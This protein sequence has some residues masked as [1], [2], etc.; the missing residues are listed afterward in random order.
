MSFASVIMENHQA[1][2][3]ASKHLG[4]LLKLQQ[5][6][7]PERGSGAEGNDAT[8]QGVL[9]QLFTAAEERMETDNDKRVVGLLKS[10]VVTFIKTTLGVHG[11]DHGDRPQQGK[12]SDNQ[13]SLSW[14]DVSTMPDEP[15]H[16]PRPARLDEDDDD[17]DDG[18]AERAE[19]LHL[20]KLA[21]EY[22]TYDKGDD[23][24]DSDHEDVQPAVLSRGIQP[25]GVQSRGG[26]GFQTV[27]KKRYR[28]NQYRR[29]GGVAC[30][31]FR[32]TYLHS[33]PS[34]T[35]CIPI[36][37]PS[38]DSYDASRKPRTD[39]VYLILMRC[40]FIYSIDVPWCVVN[41]S[42]DASYCRILPD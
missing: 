10:Q 25:R 34:D 8:A 14:S 26:D 18:F 42:K 38:E 21:L 11:F 4:S 20:E 7:Q 2:S 16:S 39:C 33:L 41:G 37:F 9:D 3:Q 6:Q 22:N 29:Q 31:E 19:T 5:Q 30:Q 17:E 15:S 35:Y 23:E 1:Q 32:P 36:F 40:F 12:S 24:P 28:R 27:Q 13:P